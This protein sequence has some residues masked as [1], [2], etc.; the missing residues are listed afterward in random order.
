MAIAAYESRFQSYPGYVSEVSANN[1][2]GQPLPWT[3]AILGDLDRSD[4]LDSWQNGQPITPFVDFLVCPSDPQLKPGEPDT[5][6][7]VN[8][9]NSQYDYAG[10]GMLNTKYPMRQNGKAIPHLTNSLDKVRD[11]ASRTILISENIQASLWSAPAFAGTAKS[12]WFNPRELFAKKEGMPTNVFIYHDETNVSEQWLINGK[13][14][15]SPPTIP[16]PRRPLAT[17]P[18]SMDTARPSSEH[19]G[20]VN[21]CFADGHVQFLKDSINYRVYSLLMSADGKKCNQ[22]IRKAG[23][24]PAI[25]QETPLSDNEYK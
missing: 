19:T 14:P 7:V 1:N 22:S 5:S 15:A 21:V 12:N 24:T 18:V 10:C 8:V 13:T 23:N 2:S 25:N 17:D 16:Q 3:V 6:Y 11:G 9:G 20:G 4:I